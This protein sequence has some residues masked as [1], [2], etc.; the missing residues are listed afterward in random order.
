MFLPIALLLLLLNIPYSSASEDQ[1][2]FNVTFT[3]RHPLNYQYKIEFIESDWW[4]FNGD[5]SITKERTGVASPGDFNIFLVGLQNGDE[6]TSEV[7][8]CIL[9][10][11]NSEFQGYDVRMKLTH[12]CTKDHKEVKIYMYIYP[13]C[14]IG[15]GICHF[16]I[17]RDITDIEG[18]IPNYANL[19]YL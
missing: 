1:F 2:V 9:I 14:E 17:S 6:L 3:C 5:D 15:K 19:I 11:E 13:H 4:I 18:E 10:L 12:N 7:L 8:R 16:K